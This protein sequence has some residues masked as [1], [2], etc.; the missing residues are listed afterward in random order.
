MDSGN[1]VVCT[2][3]RDLAREIINATIK[4]NHGIASHF[5]ALKE[6]FSEI[7]G[8]KLC[9]NSFIKIVHG[10]TPP[11][12][13]LIGNQCEISI[14]IALT[15]R[16]EFWY[17]TCFVAENLDDIR[18]YYLIY[19]ACFPNGPSLK[20]DDTLGGGTTASDVVAQKIADGRIVLCI[21]DSDKHSPDDK[22][23][24]TAAKV[25]KLPIPPSCNVVITESHEIENLFLA[26]KI[27]EYLRN[28]NLT[29]R[30]ADV[31]RIINTAEKK[32]I[33]ARFYYDIKSGYNY[34]TIASNAYLHECFAPS[35]V[36]CKSFTTDENCKNCKTCNCLIIQG[37][38][39]KFFS[40]DIL[41]CE[42]LKDNI[43][44]IYS[45]LPDFVKREWLRMASA[46]LSWCCA[47]KLNALGV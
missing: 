32:Q 47:Y 21:L 24:D 17:K 19:K 8:V 39:R 18:G 16:S 13:R 15:T 10:N 42:S 22:I 11:S 12:A 28:N 20:S 4:T 6:H 43:V 9:V 29:E 1:H 38:G 34:K 45:E 2:Q 36:N 25:L 14:G 40:D 23:K 3:T 33:D 46:V 31:L 5:D 27:L 37:L 30:D 44:T 35:K 7:A 26:K 41:N